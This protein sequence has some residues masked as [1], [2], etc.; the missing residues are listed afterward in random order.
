LQIAGGYE[1]EYGYDF[2]GVDFVLVEGFEEV[3]DG[4]NDGACGVSLGGWEVDP[5]EGG[6]CELPFGDVG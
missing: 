1:F 2:I 6:S 3:A 5:E 4:C